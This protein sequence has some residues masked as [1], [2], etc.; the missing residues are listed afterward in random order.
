MVSFCDCNLVVGGFGS[1]VD[2]GCLW[3]VCMILGFDGVLCF[4]RG[5]DFTALGLP[6]YLGLVYLFWLLLVFGFVSCLLRLWLSG[7]AVFVLLQC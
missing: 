2:L 3:L 1:Y 7:L 5:S 4:A 6:D